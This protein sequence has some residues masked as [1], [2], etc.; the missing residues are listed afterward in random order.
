MLERLDA[1]VSGNSHLTPKFNIAYTPQYGPNMIVTRQVI[2][3]IYV[4]FI[5]YVCCPMTG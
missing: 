2:I 4:H 3:I 1:G 5:A